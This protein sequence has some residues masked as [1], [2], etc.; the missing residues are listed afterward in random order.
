MM[1]VSNIPIFQYSSVYMFLD[2]TQLYFICESVAFFFN[3][4][5]KNKLPLLL[6]LE[7]GEHNKNKK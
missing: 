7:N 6:D 4:Y 3:L 1:G 2:W 5:K